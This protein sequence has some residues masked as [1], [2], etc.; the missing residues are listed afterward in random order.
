[1]RL[2]LKNSYTKNKKHQVIG[3]ILFLIGPSAQAGAP[4]LTDDPVILEQ[5]KWELFLFSALDLNNDLFLEPYLYAPTIQVN[6]GIFKR[7]EL[8]I[9]LPYAMALPDA[10]P[11]SKGFGDMQL[12]VKFQFIEETKTM[13][14]IGTAPVLWIPTGNAD[15]NLGNGIPWFKI[16]ILAQKSWGKWTTYGGGG[17]VYN[18]AP[19]MLHFF[20]ANWLLQKEVKDNLT[21]GGEVFYE[22]AMT[23]DGAASLILNAGG[24][25][26]FTKNFA[27]Q[28][29]VGHSIAG[30]E[31]LLGYLGLYW[32]IGK[33]SSSSLNKMHQQAS[34]ANVNGAH[35]NQ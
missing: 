25:Y 35:K 9:I 24:I 22:E 12:G 8:D 33:D 7:V 2:L 14:Q 1:M 20:Y 26:N 30:Q 6:Y 27:L 32:S 16:P 29:S 34:S 10:A 23:F 21:L 13:P 5:K 31:H 18:S 15:Q 3:L 11:F 28:F 19:G 17:Y 4:F